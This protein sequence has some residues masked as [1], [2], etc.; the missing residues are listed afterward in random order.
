MLVVKLVLKKYDRE[1]IT[2]AVCAALRRLLDSNPRTP[3][4][5]PELVHL[6]A[7]TSLQMEARHVIDHPTTEFGR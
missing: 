7:P 6:D 5:R 4:C 3:S 2:Y 1:L